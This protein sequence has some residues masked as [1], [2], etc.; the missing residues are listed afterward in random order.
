MV[1]GGAI[2]TRDRSMSQAQQDMN[3]KI[4]DFEHTEQ[5]YNISKACRFVG[6][7]RNNL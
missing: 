3:R 2:P 5:S 6:I 4:G 1:L 7:C